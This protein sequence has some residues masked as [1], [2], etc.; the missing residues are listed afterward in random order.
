MDTSVRTRDHITPDRLTQVLD[1]GANPLED[2]PPYAAML[3]SGTCHVTGFEPQPDALTRLRAA[4]GPHETYLPHAVADGREHRLHI[5]APWSGCSSLFEPDPAQFALLVDFP[6]MARV[7]DTIEVSTVRLDD[8]DLPRLDHLKMDVQ[9]SELLILENGPRT[10]EHITS[11]QVEVAFHRLYRDQPL[12]GEV[13][14][15]L[16]ALGFVPQH[17]V[18]AVVDGEPV[19]T[20]SWPL[21]PVPWALD[22]GRGARQLLEADMLYVRDLAHLDL[23]DDDQLVHL[24]LV[25]EEAFGQWGV[26]LRALLELEDR[27]VVTRGS[28]RR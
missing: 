21:A 6:E 9:G 17:L 19:T 1:I 16:R 11:V 18:P 26:A 12:F 28:E 22:R 24:A 23:L 2:E 10:L 7:V 20:K 15:E 3:R 13:D 14:A 4:A 5:C 25:C 27:G 8:L